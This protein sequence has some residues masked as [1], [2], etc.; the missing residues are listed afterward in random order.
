MIFFE[1]QAGFARYYNKRYNRRGYCCG[2]RLMSVIVE[3]EE[4]LINCQAYIDLYPLHAGIVRNK[5]KKKVRIKA[6]EISRINRF[7]YRTRYFT[8]SGI[9]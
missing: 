8:N 6:F 5:E 3:W 7:R 2:D 4:T 1:I 9:I